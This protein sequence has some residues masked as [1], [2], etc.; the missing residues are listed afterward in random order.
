VIII[1]EPIEFGGWVIFVAIT[2]LCWGASSSIGFIGGSILSLQFLL[3]KIE[4]VS[5]ISI[6]R[7]GLET[8]W[9]FFSSI[10]FWIFFFLSY[11]EKT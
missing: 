7:I 3:K 5:I 4:N 2:I 1:I 9:C 8:L 6:I 11:F 10:I